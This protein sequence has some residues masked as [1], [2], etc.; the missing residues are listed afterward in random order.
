MAKN[1]NL[2][3]LPGWTCPHIDEVISALDIPMNALLKTLVDEYGV[4]LDSPVRVVLDLCDEVGTS[5]IV[6]VL[7][8]VRTHA[9]G[10]RAGAE[11]RQ[12]RI[13]ELESE[14]SDASLSDAEKDERIL[15]LEERVL[16]LELQLINTQVEPA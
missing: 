2:D 12:R 7:E 9:E 1:P 16:D 6:D 4:G 10:L 8:T 15:E 3:D 5:S 13:E 11:R 14:A